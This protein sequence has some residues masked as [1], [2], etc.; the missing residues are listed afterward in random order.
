[1]NDPELLQAWATRR[2]E[3]AFAELVR[4]HLG[5]VYGSALRQVREPVLAQ[6]V[7]QAVFL[8]LADKAGTLGDSVVLSGWL[9]RTTRFVAARAMRAERRRTHHE[10][11]AAA[12]QRID[13]DASSSAATDRWDEVGPHLD[14]ALAA[15][16]ATDRNAVLLRFFEKQPLRAVGDRLGLGEEAAKKR[17]SRAV[18]KLRA[19]LAGKGVVLTAAGLLALLTEMPS[20][21]APAGLADSITDAVGTGSA[22]PAATELAKG[23]AR[24]WFTARLLDVA[25]WFA[26]A[27]VLLMA[28]GA[29][30]AAP[31][32]SAGSQVAA[33]SAEG[34]VIPTSASTSAVS[35]VLPPPAQV[36]PSRI[37]LN[38][39]SAEDNRPLAARGMA[40]FWAWRS[41]LDR[42][43]VT[44]DANGFIEIP[45]TDPKLD[46]LRLFVSSPGSCARHPLVES[47]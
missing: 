8:V 28:G 11:Q 23:A 39:R 31:T 25:P 26:A 30:W 4:R 32:S 22:G 14:A 17:V 44:T 7:A 13:L 6:E 3:P 5:L 34:T 24:D 10:Q 29:W 15:L 12:M 1:M 47:A 20:S 38:V 36:G 21:A 37:L 27:L 42:Q 18:E 2:D 33:A 45:V 40:V 16:P 19:F 43:E 41:V 46:S 9:F 35:T